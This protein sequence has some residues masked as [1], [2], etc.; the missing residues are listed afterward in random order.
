MS[1]TAHQMGNWC[2]SGDKLV[3]F[4]HPCFY[5]E[6]FTVHRPST[7]SI[8]VFSSFVLHLIGGLRIQ[9][10]DDFRKRLLAMTVAVDQNELTMIVE[11]DLT[12]WSV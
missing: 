10:L 3:G 12:H 5:S 1:P 2:D 6:C 8:E 9:S 7:L 4:A 11:K